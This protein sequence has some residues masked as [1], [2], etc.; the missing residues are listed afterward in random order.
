MF[1]KGHPVAVEDTVALIAGPKHRYIPA[2]QG[3]ELLCMVD[4]GPHGPDD[5]YRETAVLHWMVQRRIIEPE[6]ENK[7]VE[8]KNIVGD[9]FQV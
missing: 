5:H 7:R 2:G 9:F 3:L 4:L 8:L 1:F 6:P